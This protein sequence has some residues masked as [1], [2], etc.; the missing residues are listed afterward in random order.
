MG[1]GIVGTIVAALVTI[2]V[3]GILIGHGKQTA[4]VTK[5][6]FAGLTNFTSVANLT[7]QSRG[8]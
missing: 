4:T 5:A 7:A 6:G 3:V 1:K 2:I 8:A